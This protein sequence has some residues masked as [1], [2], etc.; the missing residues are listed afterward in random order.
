MSV[1]IITINLMCLQ[2]R[3]ASTALQGQGWSWGPCSA[4]GRQLPWPEVACGA[5]I[6]FV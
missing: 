6:C 2:E 1:A 5:V 4:N 3:D